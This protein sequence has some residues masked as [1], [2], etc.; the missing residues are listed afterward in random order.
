M[1]IYIALLRGINVSGYNKIK[2]TELKLLF[3]NEGFN[4]ITT[5]IQS[6]NVIFKSDESDTNKL[7]KQLIKAIKLQFNYSISVLIL[8]EEKLQTIYTSNPFLQ[9]SNIDI[10]K[11]YVTLLNDA[12][13]KEGIPLLK[14]YSTKQEEFYIDNKTVYLYYPNGYGRSKLTNN[15]IESKLKTSATSRNWKTISKL[16][17][18]NSKKIE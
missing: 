6:G 18:L 7:E 4:D 8:A 14:S 10:S 3:I 16:V 1:S 17:E 12:P 11:L 15:V 2:M 13:F 5:Y 9:R